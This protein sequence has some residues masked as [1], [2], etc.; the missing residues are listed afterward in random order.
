MSPSRLALLKIKII[1]ILAQQD[2]LRRD[3]LQEA[4]HMR[5]RFAGPLT[6]VMSEGVAGPA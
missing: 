6:P 1:N 2:H 4:D 3:H 5:N